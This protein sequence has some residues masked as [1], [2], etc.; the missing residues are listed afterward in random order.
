MT[1]KILAIDDDAYCLQLIRHWLEKYDFEVTTSSDA[2]E[3]LR[4]FRRIQPHLVILDI[5]LPG[6]SGW[7]ACEIIRQRS[8]VPLLMLT[9]LSSKKDVVRGFDL[10]VDDYLVKPF[11]ADELVARVRALLRRSRARPAESEDILRFQ[12]GY[13]VIRPASHEVLVNGRVVE[14]T[15]IEYELLLYLALQPGRAVAVNDI[16]S[17]VWQFDSGIDQGNVKWYIW[18]LR[19]KIERDPRNPNLLCT[20]RGVGY[21]FDG[22][23]MFPGK[24]ASKPSR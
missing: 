10:G 2:E 13:L 23:L 7:E 21:R 14:L 9:A 5:M 4:E 18:R 19:S 6:I 22:G 16:F 15:P 24:I 8:T 12:D 3:G 11:V 17:Q 1:D 20:V